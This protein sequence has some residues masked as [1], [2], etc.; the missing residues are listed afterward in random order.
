MGSKEGEGKTRLAFQEP[1]T[2]YSHRTVP[3]PEACSIALKQH[4]AR[5]A[6]EWLLLGQAFQDHGLVFC[7]PDGRPIDPR[8]LNDHFEKLLKRV[9]LPLIRLHDLRHTFAT[10]MLEL[11]ES[12]KTV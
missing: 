9:G 4:K 3:I 2:A 11:G 10:W 12:P 6:E 8:Y 5:Q 7:W 1:K